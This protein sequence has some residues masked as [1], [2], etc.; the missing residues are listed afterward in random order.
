MSCAA[1]YNQPTVKPGC[2]LGCTAHTQARSNHSATVITRAAAAAVIPQQVSTDK[3]PQCLKTAR[4]TALAAALYM[5]S[6]GF[7]PPSSR[8]VFYRAQYEPWVLKLNGTDGLSPYQRQL[9]LR[10]DLIYLAGHRTG[11]V[12]SQTAGDGAAMR[13][14]IHSHLRV[15][16]YTSTTPTQPS[17]PYP[18]QHGSRHEA[19]LLQYRYQGLG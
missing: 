4:T 1:Q 5:F 15:D 2:V 19:S 11:T 8:R 16:T 17:P 12:D 6:R 3:R 9:A 13:R 14:Y 7:L 18:V 10:Q